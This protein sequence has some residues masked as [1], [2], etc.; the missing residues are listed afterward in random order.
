MALLLCQNVCP[1]TL[2]RRNIMTRPETTQNDSRR[3]E[4]R[5]HPED[6]APADA[7]R[8]ERT[9]TRFVDPYDMRAEPQPEEPGYGHGV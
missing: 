2:D 4:E 6:D 5:R 9:V 3:V 1:E 7:R 8:R